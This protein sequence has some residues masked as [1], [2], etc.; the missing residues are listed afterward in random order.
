VD[1]EVDSLASRVGLTLVRVV[2]GA[3]WNLSDK[4]P[5]SSDRSLFRSLRH[6]VAPNAP[7]S[8]LDHVGAYRPCEHASQSPIVPW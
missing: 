3:V 4:R 6:A 2:I 8:L 7:L 5:Q 1:S